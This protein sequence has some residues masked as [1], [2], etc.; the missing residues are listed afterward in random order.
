MPKQLHSISDGVQIQI[1]DTP[2]IWGLPMTREGV[3]DQAKASVQ[4]LADTIY[5]M[6][7]GAKH[8][9]DILSLN[10]ADGVFLAALKRG[11]LALAKT[12]NDI[13]IRFLFGWVPTRDTVAVF[14]A[15]LAEFCR[16][17]GI[18]THQITI[19][20]GQYYSYK[21]FW[22]HAKIVAVDGKVA[23]V[24]GHN[25]WD[26]AYGK[27][28]PVHDI[29]VRVQGEAAEGTH[30]F[31]DFL[32]ENAGE[33]LTIWGIT[34]EYQVVE[35]KSQHERDYHSMDMQVELSDM[36]VVHRPSKPKLR[37]ESDSSWAE[38]EVELADF[39]GANLANDRR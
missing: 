13:T 30:G 26:S 28:P 11:L 14:R 31:A 7:A 25:L 32:W 18:S 1:I 33:Y 2:H 17:H 6:I 24:G 4:A 36:S 3:A 38:S 16:E 39:S 12:D 35:R 5:E 9:I 19:L 8:K 15:S 10:P 20:I 23:L 22:N 29:S 37:K 27:Y 21:M 34:G